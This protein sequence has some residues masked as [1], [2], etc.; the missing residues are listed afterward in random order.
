MWIP[1]LL[2]HSGQ[3]KVVKLSLCPESNG[4]NS[5]LVHSSLRDTDPMENGNAVCN[6]V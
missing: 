6:L 2:T 1:F 4:K 5:A 3:I